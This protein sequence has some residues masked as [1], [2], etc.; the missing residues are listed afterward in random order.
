MQRKPLFWFLI[1]AV[2]LAGAIYFWRLGDQWQAQQNAEP[3]SASQAPGKSVVATS[4][5]TNA[6]AGRAC[7]HRRR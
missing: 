5:K 4:S 2:C 1:S 7:R 3:K 6:A